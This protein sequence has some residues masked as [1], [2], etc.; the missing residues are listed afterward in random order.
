MGNQLHLLWASY[1][2]YLNSEFSSG[3]RK[4]ESQEKE[5]MTSI[6]RKLERARKLSDGKEDNE[7]RANILY[8]LGYFYYKI[9]D[10]FASEEVLEECVKIKSTIKNPARKLLDEFWNYQT[11]PNVIEWWLASPL[12]C[13]KKRFIFS[14]LSLSILLLFLIPISDPDYKENWTPYYFF[15]VFIFIIIILPRIESFKAK[16]LEVKFTLPPFLILLCLPP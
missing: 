6:I 11:K 7:T 2:Y 12:H 14:V 15:I 3:L 5:N 10:N 16:E 8:L 9:H 4:D 1:A 13:W